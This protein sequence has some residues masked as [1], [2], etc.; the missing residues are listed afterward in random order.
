M[1]IIKQISTGGAELLLVKISKECSEHHIGINKNGSRLYLWDG[2][3]LSTQLP[4]DGWQLLG[5]SDQLAEELCKELIG[6]DE[7][8]KDLGYFLPVYGYW[9]FKYYKTLKEAF[10]TLMQSCEAYKENPCGE[11][12]INV[13]GYYG[14]DMVVRSIVSQQRKRYVLWNEAEA[15][16]GSWLVL[17]KLSDEKITE[18]EIEAMLQC[19]CCEKSRTSDEIKEIFPG[20]LICQTCFGEFQVWRIRKDIQDP[21]A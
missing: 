2:K 13:G 20:K 3:G 1:D 15:N 21:D 12:P 4:S 18:E 9:G 19:T 14:G 5:L 7:Y 8:I 11:E 17:K 6:A 10:S 16:T